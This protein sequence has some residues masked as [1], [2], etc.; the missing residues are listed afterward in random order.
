MKTERNQRDCAFQNISNIFRQKP[1]SPNESVFSKKLGE[2]TQ[3]PIL[4]LVSF[5]SF[6]FLQSLL[7][8]EVFQVFLDLSRSI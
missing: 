5:I 6:F 2:E 7:G 3:A 4:S 8:Y 1:Y